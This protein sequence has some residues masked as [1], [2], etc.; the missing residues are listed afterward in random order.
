[1][2]ARLHACFCYCGRAALRY[3][4]RP[5]EPQDERE[6]KEFLVPVY[7][8]LLPLLPLLCQRCALEQGRGMGPHLRFS[9]TRERPLDQLSVRLCAGFGAKSWVLKLT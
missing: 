5:G 2:A 8:T 3:T 6:R 1:M 9:C 7:V 4:L